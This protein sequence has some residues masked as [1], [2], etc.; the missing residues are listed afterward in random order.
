MEIPQNRSMTKLQ[1]DASTRE[2]YRLNFDDPGNLPKTMILMK[3]P[4]PFIEAENDFLILRDYLHDCGIPVPEIFGKRPAEGKIYLGDCGDLLLE[5]ALTSASADEITRHYMNV[6][7]I[8]VKMQVHCTSSLAIGN[9]ATTRKFDTAKYMYELEHAKK[10]F[11]IGHLKKNLSPEEDRKLTNWFLEL[12]TP[13][14]KEPLVFSHRDYHSRNIMIKDGNYFI[15]DFQ[16]AMMGPAQY[17]LV[18]LLF[19]SYVRLDDG[20]RNR[21]AA[22]YIEKLNSEDGNPVKG[23]NIAKNLI[24]VSLQR[25]IKALGTFGFQAESRKN[26]FFLKYVPNTFDYVKS[27]IVKMDEFAESAEWILSLLAP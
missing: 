19:D 7:D 10:W 1:G 26:P 13:L 16:D 8:L 11:I 3:L 24:R 27:N 20:I 5:G 21:L 18:S 9:P 12:V 14:E 6:I 2:Y 4:A 25:N 22:Y 15:L 23:I 17:D